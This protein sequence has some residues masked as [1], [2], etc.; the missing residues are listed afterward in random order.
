MVPLIYS[1]ADVDRMVRYAE[2]H[3]ISHNVLTNAPDFTPYLF[4]L[5]LRAACFGFTIEE[6]APGHWFRHLSVLPVFD[7][8][9]IGHLCREFGIDLDSP[10]ASHYI[11]GGAIN[12][13]QPCDPPK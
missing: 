3:P 13:D 11:D 2:S 10:D 12:I 1:K 8:A 6:Q 7:R 4:W 9:V 5:P